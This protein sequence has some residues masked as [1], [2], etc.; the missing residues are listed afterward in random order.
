MDPLT[1]GLIVGLGLN[2]A[3][4]IGNGIANYKNSVK[5]DRALRAVDVIKSQIKE[6]NANVEKDM[7]VI[8]A[9]LDGAWNHI[10]FLRYQNPQPQMMPQQFVQQPPVQPPVQPQQVAQPPQQQSIQE[11][12]QPTQLEQLIDVLKQTN[13]TVENLKSEFD[14]LKQQQL[15]K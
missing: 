12:L 9:D 8:K 11:Q 10:N 7:K 3:G 15:G 6:N 14:D 4:N 1:I 13:K 2:A 5:S